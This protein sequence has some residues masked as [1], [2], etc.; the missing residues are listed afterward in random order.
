MKH[1]VS[2]IQLLC[3]GILLT[4]CQREAV[5]VPAG[6]SI[7]ISAGVE[8][9]RA[10]LNSGD[11][12]AGSQIS[13]YD[14]LSD[15]LYTKHI[16]G[17]VASFQAAG[18]PWAFAGMPPAVY[19]WRP[20]QKICNHNFFTWLTRDPSGLTPSSIFGSN[21]SLAS[22][23]PD[24]GIYRVN[25]PSTTMTL[26][27][28]QFDF[29]YSD[30]VT[31]DVATSNYSTVNLEL[32]HFFTAFA[33]KAHNY[34]SDP[35][36]V[37]SVKLYGIRNT[38]R[39]VI[40][41]DTNDPGSQASVEYT[42]ASSSWAGEAKGLEL[43]RSSITLDPDQDLNNIITC[44]AGGS[45]TTG[46]TDA[47][48]LMWP[49]TE[50]EMTSS[51]DGE[52]N[53]I[54][55]Y[56]KAILAVTYRSGIS[57]EVTK[58]V[59]LCP[60]GKTQAWDP[61]TFHQLELSFTSKFVTLDVSV[62][63]WDYLEKDVNYAKTIACNTNGELSFVDGTCVRDDANHRIYFRN[64]ATPIRGYFSFASPVNGSW[65]ISKNGDFDAFE[66]D[67]ESLGEWGD[68]IDFAYGT[69]DGSSVSYFTIYPI[70]QDPQK[71]YSIQ[72]AFAVRTTSGEVYSADI[73]VQGEDPSQYYTIILQ[74]LN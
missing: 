56:S 35:I 60:Q 58:C 19:S 16:N 55:D 23:S 9:T 62:L 37:T 3:I 1:T 67:N 64:S 7:M 72:L 12:V 10:L 68:G 54:V 70:D 43:L 30:I 2:T 59:S 17:V 18:D 13:V 32:R 71:D 38:K 4:G 8:Q 20:D 5:Q 50:A 53:L 14:V 45:K 44:T 39:A 33:I 49:Q 52:G 15:G 42:G 22:N 21:L 24:N 40:T 57:P 66:I 69:I 48:Y 63:P 73:V 36:T 27:S 6:D 31:R 34:D 26:G 51:Y 65:M 41:Y 11:L 61:G 28:R 74:S 29:C 25:V 46:A 47:K